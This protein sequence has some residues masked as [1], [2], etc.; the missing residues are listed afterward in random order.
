MELLNGENA[1]SI[2]NNPFKK[3]CV[4]DILIRYTISNFSGK[5]YWYGKVEFKNGN[6]QGLQ[7]FIGYTPEDFKRLVKDIENFVNTL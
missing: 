2:L 4:I 3:E 7:E 6:T 1:I 5:G